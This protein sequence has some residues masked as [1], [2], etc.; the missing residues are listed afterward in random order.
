MLFPFWLMRILCFVRK[1]A[2]SEFEVGRCVRASTKPHLFYVYL[3][4]WFDMSDDLCDSC[5]NNEWRLAE[6]A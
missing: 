1:S 4:C 5:A 6:K 3:V 2:K